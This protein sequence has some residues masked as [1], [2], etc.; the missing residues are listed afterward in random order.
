[1]ANSPGD[2]SD[3]PAS[4]GS[5]SENEG[6]Q[7]DHV[8]DLLQK[9]ERQARE[10]EERNRLLGLEVALGAILGSTLPLQQL[11]TEALRLIVNHLHVAHVSAWIFSPQGDLEWASSAGDEPRQVAIPRTLT[12]RP[13]DL[14]QL[15]HSP[16]PGREDP[17]PSIVVQA[18]P[19]WLQQKQIAQFV[20]SPL[21]IGERKLGLLGTWSATELSADAVTVLGSVA[22]AL[23]RTAERYRAV[24]S[25]RVSEAWLATT[26]SSIGDGVIATD[27]SGRVTYANPIALELTGRAS[28]DCVGVHLD[29]IFR[30]VNETTREPLES[31]IAKVLRVGGI[32]GVLN[33]TILLRPDGSELSI[34]DSASPI[35]SGDGTLSGIVLVFR[36]VTEK[37]AAERERTGLLEASR[38]AQKS[39]KQA[40][41]TL[42]ALFM[43]APAAICILRGADHVFELANPRYTQLVGGRDVLGLS[44]R[45]ALPHLA[46]QGLFELLDR[47]YSTGERFE[48]KEVPV[49]LNR[50]SGE[51]TEEFLDFV[52]EPLLSHEGLI[53]GVLVL[54][55]DVTEKVEARRALERALAQAD[56]LNRDLSEAES[57]LRRL[58]DN[59]PELAWSARP[60]GYIDFY[61]RR[62]FDYTGT[63]AEDMVGWGW[64][65]VHDP[66]TVETVLERWKHSIQT[67]ERFEMEYPLRGANGAFR[68]FLTR[69]EPLRD[70]SNRVVR[71][72][73]TNTD[74]H[75]Q[76]EE[77]IK[78]HEAN[79]AKDEFLATASHEL[80]SP[81]SAILGWARLLRT[82]TADPSML[83]RGL[84]TIERNATAQVQLIDDIL[85]GSRIITGNLRL[86]VK[87]VD[88]TWVVQSALDTVRPA[89][90]AKQIQITATLHPAAGRVLGDAGRLQ[91]IVWNL[92]NNAVKFTPKGGKID[93]TLTRLAEHIQL[94]V[95]DS[96]EGID[97]DF[98]PHVF[99]RFSQADAS[100]TRRHGGLGL[101]LALVRYLVEAHGGTVDA[102][103]AGVGRGA[104]FRVELPVGM[105]EED[106][107]EVLFEAN[108][109]SSAAR[110]IL[111]GIEVLVVD[112]DADG[113]DLVATVLRMHGAKVMSAG[114]AGEALDLFRQNPVPVI[115]S[116]LG[117]PGMDG[118]ELMRRIRGFSGEA[119]VRVRAVALT[120][121]VRDQDRQRA[122]DAGFQTHLSKPVEPAE[123]V[124][125]VSE[126]ASRDSPLPSFSPFE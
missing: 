106:L 116:D 117:M 121:Y 10:L 35:R 65:S 42:H 90:S 88:L 101:G 79:M 113:R 83:S 96:G 60:D 73:G 107:E 99:D 109:R 124:R 93:V 18:D 92:A 71:W 50:P 11:F 29:E 52:Y 108:E 118:L 55:T 49:T 21:E 33:H 100:A 8:H 125:V 68:W 81:L 57:V 112:D 31:P 16:Q 27:A 119:G 19:V 38:K 3:G 12:F 67:G 34:E 123:L 75:K 82:G 44:V 13:T 84:E 22:K 115:V 46:D 5:L 72:F 54:A 97:P 70:S 41:D 6:G 48:G 103:S 91:Q 126:L 114:S 40:R 77:G 76:R 23:A 85:D 63:T 69:V 78:A 120:A 56:H 47:V 104:R 20:A 45:K 37:R 66:A 30:I 74:I 98:L 7:R 9:L 4:I 53:D 51:R 17:R 102:Q 15:S 25:V 105:I 39:A 61:N 95:S 62:W 87:P 80:R 36:D 59:L 64:V 110:A 58:V 2:A 14:Q 43:Q 26:L 94:T 1:M 111:D 122:L 86:E 24:E 32:V 89:A 28:A